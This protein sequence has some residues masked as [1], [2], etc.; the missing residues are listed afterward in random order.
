MFCLERG[1]LRSYLNKN[2]R[3]SKWKPFWKKLKVY[4][5]NVLDNLNGLL[6]VTCNTLHVSLLFNVFFSLNMKTSNYERHKN[7][8][9]FPFEMKQHAVVK[10][11]A[12]AL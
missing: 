8:Q 9:K 1:I 3:I 6:L 2:K 12:L 11:V 10:M 4:S 7:R 5:I